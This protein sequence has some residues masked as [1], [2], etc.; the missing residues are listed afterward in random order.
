MSRY[1]TL[2]N[3]LEGASASGNGVTFIHGPEQEDFLSY[4][5]LKNEAAALL[6]CLNAEGVGAGDFLILQI[7][8][9][10][11]FLALFWACI[12]GGIVP[13]PMTLADSNAYRNKLLNAWK[14]VGPTAFV[15]FDPDIYKGFEKWRLQRGLDRFFEQARERILFPDRFSP[16]ASFAP[17]RKEIPPGDAAYVQFSSGSTGT[18]KGV[19]VSHENLLENIDAFLLAKK[20]EPSDSYISWLPLTHDMG[21]IGW[22]LNPMA[23]GVNQYLMPPETFMG[24]PCLWFDKIS[25]HG[26]RIAGTPNFGLSHLLKSMQGDPEKEWDLSCLR[27]IVI[28]AEPISHTLSHKFL[29]KMAPYGLK[30]NT[31]MPGYGLAEAT[32]AV[33]VSPCGEDFRTHFLDSRSLGTG[34]RVADLPRQSPFC[35]PYVDEGALLPGFS[36]K[37]CDDG[38]NPLPDDT[39]G[40]ILLSGKSVARG[41]LNNKAATSQAFTREG[42]LRTGDLGFIRNNRLIITGRAREIIIIAGMNFFPHDIERSAARAAGTGAVAVCG[43]A[44]PESGVEELV[45]FV[46]FKKEITSFVSVADRVREQVAKDF[47]LP[48]S[49]VVPLGSIPRTSSGKVRRTWLAERYRQGVFDDVL[50]RLDQLLHIRLKP[51][52][53]FAMALDQRLDAMAGFVAEQVRRLMG[54]DWVDPDRSLVSQGVDSLMAVALRNIIQAAFGVMVPISRFRESTSI[55][56]F[57]NFILE[58]MPRKE[59]EMPRFRTGASKALPSSAIGEAPIPIGETPFSMSMGQL[60]I[61][62]DYMVR[63]K[64]YAYNVRFCFQINSGIDIHIFE[65][66]FQ[67]LMDRHEILRTTYGF[68]NDRAMQTV[69]GH[70]DAWVVRADVQG[71]DR[72]RIRE[73]LLLDARNPF[74]LFQGPPARMHLYSRA[75]TEHYCMLV[76]HHIACDSRTMVLLA[77]ELLRQY[78]RILQGDRLSD[79]PLPGSQYADFVRWERQF[80]EGPEYLE[81]EAFWD[82]I[83]GGDL[84]DLEWPK[85][86]QPRKEAC[87]PC[88]TRA[89]TLAVEI[90]KDL[91][92]AVDLLA[93]QMGISVFS[94]FFSAFSL[95]LQQYAARDDILVTIPA[96]LFLSLPANLL[97]ESVSGY[98]VNPVV[99][100]SVQEK[101]LSRYLR[102]TGQRI[103]QALE[104]QAYPFQKILEKKGW[105]RTGH[106][107]PLTRVMC[108]SLSF[109]GEKKLDLLAA[110]MEKEGTVQAFGLELRPFFLPWQEGGFDLSLT[111]CRAGHS[112]YAVLSWNE[113]R[114]DSWAAQ[115]MVADF[116]ALVRAMAQEPEAC[117]ADLAGSCTVPKASPPLIPEPRALTCQEPGKARERLGREKQGQR[118]N[119][120]PLDGTERLLIS[121]FCKVLDRE[122]LDMTDHFFECGG[123]SLRAMRVVAQ[124]RNLF[125]VDIP[126]ADLFDHPV[127]SDFCAIVK[128]AIQERGKIAGTGALAGQNEETSA[129]QNEKAPA[130]QNG[131]MPA[132]QAPDPRLLH[133]LFEEQARKR[134]EAHAL[135]FEGQTLSYGQL[136][137]RADRLARALQLQGVGPGR[138]AALYLERSMEMII[139]IL[140]I[141]K[142]GG[143]YVP[144]DP[145]YPRERIRYI[146][147]DSHPLVILTQED[148]KAR[149]DPEAASRAICMESLTDPVASGEARLEILSGD[150]EGPAYV[151]FTS[152][153]TGR[154]KGVVVTHANA[155]RLFTATEQWFHFNEQDTWTLFH[156]IAFDFSVWEVFGA[157][158]YGGKLVIVPFLT[159]RSPASFY[160]LLKEARITVLNQTPTAFRQLIQAQPAVNTDPLLDLRVVIFGGEALNVRDLKPWLEGQ[161][162]T[163]PQL[164]NMYGITETTV[165]ATYRPISKADL[166]KKGSRI[167]HPLPDLDFY[168][169][170]EDLHPVPDMTPGEIFVGG[171]GV[172]P[173]YLGRPELTRERFI[174]NPFDKG[175]TRLYRSGDLAR[176]LPDGDMEYLGRKDNQV[177][178]YG[179]RIELSEIESVLSG[180]EKVREN[181]ALLQR[182]ASGHAHIVAHVAG[183]VDVRDLRAFLGKTLPPY[184]VPSRFV[185]VERLPM[186]A[187]GKVDRQALPDP[188][189]SPGLSV[190]EIE[191]KLLAVWQGLI[192]K[193]DIGV[194]DDFFALGGSSLD[195]MKLGVRIQ[196][197][198]GRDV[199]A[200]D[201]FAETTVSGQARLVAQG[202]KIQAPSSV[203]P[204]TS[205]EQ[206]YPV[207]HSQQRM[208]LLDRI[209]QGLYAYNVPGSFYLKGHLDR[210]ALE[211]SLERI[212]ARHETLRT[213]FVLAREAL[214]QRVV[215]ASGFRLEMLDFSDRDDPEKAAMGHLQD[216]AILP[217]DLAGGPLFRAILARTG[218]REH[219][220]FLNMHHIVSDGWSVSVLTRELSLFYNAFQRGETPEIPDLPFQYKAFA[221]QQRRAVENGELAESSRFFQEMFQELPP[222]LNLPLDYPRPGIK[223]YEGRT[224][225]TL[226]SQ[227]LSSE[228]T[229]FCRS[230]RVSLFMFF[231]TVVKLL[232]YRDTGQEDLVTGSPVA[233]R[234]RIHLDRQIGLYANTIALR[235]RID[236]NDSLADLLAKERET[237]LSALLHQEYPFDRLI[238]EIG[239][240]RRPD[241]SPLFD[242][243]VVVQNNE[244]FLFSLEGV[245]VQFWMMDNPT[246][247]FDLLLGLDEKEGCLRLQ[248]E[249]AACLFREERI[250][251]MASRLI[252][253]CEIFVRQP[254]TLIS[255]I[256]LGEGAVP[257]RKRSQAP[258]D[259]DP[260][261]LPEE[262][263]SA[264]PDRNPA[265][266]PSRTKAAD[267]PEWSEKRIQEMLIAIWEDVL[268]CGP[269]RITDSFFSLGGNSILLVRAHQALEEKFPGRL[270]VEDLFVHTTIQKITQAL[271]TGK[272]RAPGA[273]VFPVLPRAWFSRQT[274]PG[275]FEFVID[276][277]L[278]EEMREMGQALGRGGREIMLAAFAYL[279]FE[280]SGQD[281]IW[282]ALVQAGEGIK[283]PVFDF[284]RFETP[285]DLFQ[286]SAAVFSTQEPV[287]SGEAFSGMAANPESCAVFPLISF[288]EGRG[289]GTSH[290][291]LLFC[292]TLKGDEVLCTFKTSAR[293]DRRRGP[294]MIDTLIQVLISMTGAF[295]RD[296]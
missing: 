87:P 114:I 95:L 273:S 253:L 192:Q 284:S 209:T 216:A 211:K 265:L 64:G 44:D 8:D 205:K 152:G 245:E 41:Y 104:H 117:I 118:E 10:R 146:L 37:I 282:L 98:L 101:S 215:D 294:E 16:G 70:M 186:T 1:K 257:D 207:S 255:S 12:W 182:D 203:P 15:A 171:P 62:L 25:E 262:G 103:S 252:R 188:F 24:R 32:L 120:A 198:F 72:D 197:A 278:L 291:D 237:I 214:Y 76:I 56:A 225:F 97:D 111:M 228:I 31:L 221:N 159:S 169:L 9:Q 3:M 138:F 67:G 275:E 45:V 94:V 272:D 137:T 256:Q 78:D 193:Q 286:R 57:S 201:L 42:W 5:D 194:D 199:S 174:P 107:A 281:R 170:S 22:H 251:Q 106:Q 38:D 150:R 260:G 132:R 173:G 34:C 162:E 83:L 58:H 122:T 239:V 158:C 155:V 202:R 74:D 71:F 295:K 210:N 133:H 185:V 196:E 85:G 151:I 206:L 119:K 81:M 283:T 2:I 157:L 100:R 175:R 172:S 279:L 212:V 243:M 271:M 288:E 226:F 53:L 156:S 229:E 65:S 63:P 123:H 178:L 235:T 49:R 250:V 13:V 29:E 55:R 234:S 264:S 59:S 217:F 124:I 33:S 19:L 51:S 224:R 161:G 268:Q 131:K 21:L 240:E 241:R 27:L 115:S 218:P 92:G 184:M 14:I 46:S 102:K 213:V 246:S 121:L 141:L 89:T 99:I 68:D 230:R 290:V 180:H 52:D 270:T 292:P 167:G 84:P 113:S 18:P 4:A 276:T 144:L 166:E 200:K 154:P 148:L 168:L 80:L 280:I 54:R 187:H 233:G 47:N 259:I 129:G 11:R 60:S 153:T 195:I 125:H 116:K 23:A 222:L 274:A 227:G 249:Y 163:S 277:P 26:I 145:A 86:L 48:V 36:L 140:A 127:L 105:T 39:I 261:P 136:N 126:I 293:I 50:W 143:A 285:E 6:S 142:A 147:E 135:V 30:R 28:G 112:L 223:S 254:G 247:K 248:I 88:T 191:E 183:D 75:E 232:L 93:G 79:S 190:E 263:G 177:S 242:V 296:A 17:P 176:H 258:E 160:R 66:A 43:S 179:F 82:R 73:K 96:S 7:R 266:S 189:N 231:S 128:S 165:H 130:G 269:V 77:Q 267:A 35:T 287:V 110:P 208:W 108:N 109:P 20:A 61:F 139:G 69:H 149:L 220:L 204:G 91:S 164:V 40:H 219:I 238:D 181:V 236:P 134:P 289:M 90:P 244:P